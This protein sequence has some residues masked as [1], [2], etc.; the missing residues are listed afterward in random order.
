MLDQTKVY[1]CHDCRREFPPQRRH[2]DDTCIDC[3]MENGTARYQDALPMNPANIEA[4]KERVIAEDKAQFDLQTE[5]R[6]EL[7]ERAL[8]RRRFLPF[9]T[10][11][12]PNYAPGWVHAD[13]C[14]RL[15]KFAEAI[16]Q[17]RSPRLMIAM[18]PRHGKSALG[19]KTFPGWFLGR[20]ASM[21]VITCSYSGDLAKDFS[22][23]VRDMMD[24]EK[25]QTVFKT[26][27]SKSSQAVE[28]WM[29]TDGGGLAAAGV[30][31][32]ITGR[33]A[34]LGIIDDPV[35]D[36]EEAE[37]ETTRQKIK[38]WYSSTFYTRLAPGGGVLII[39][40]RWHEDDLSGWLLDVMK[41]A[42]REA[43]ETGTWPEDA[44]RWEVVNYPAVAQHDEEFRKQGEALHPDRYPLPA[45]LR[46]KRT[47]IPRDWEALY[48]QNP[49][50]QDGDYFTKGMVRYYDKAPPLNTLRIYAAADLAIGQTEQN[51]FSVFGVVG[52]CPEQ[53]LYLLDLH[54]GRWNS[55]GII[56]KMMEIQRRWNPEIF[57]VE[58]GHIDMTLEPFLLKRMAETGVHIPYEKLR[59]RGKDKVVRARPL[60]GRMEQGKVFFPRGAV[61]VEALVAEL[62]SFPLGKHDDQVD[63]LA[64]IGQMLLQFGIVNQKTVKQKSFRDKLR[65]KVV[66]GRRRSAMSA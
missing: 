38:D 49:V 7:A 57:G 46:I 5:V 24:T 58:T 27:L 51:D 39:Q 61:W 62:L 18:P 29:T 1:L 48:Q 32:P 66:G 22:R 9:V 33:G 63:M 15:E 43:N 64:W 2:D 16:E 11:V 44:D 30:Q 20:N 34:H 47:M 52:V 54:R 59:T 42:E 19:S 36:R 60:Q 23:K 6:R 3:A 14:R 31:G 56:D 40:T 65:G 37:S 53:N 13:I 25:Y 21:E 55:L 10:R 35:K 28:K 17:G 8:C 26:R 12:E 45:L 50:S 4:E 41:E